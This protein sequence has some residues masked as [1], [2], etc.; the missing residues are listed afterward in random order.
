VPDVTINQGWSDVATQVTVPL[1]DWVSVISC[2]CVFAASVP[3]TLLV[4]A[5]DSVAG[6]TDTVGSELEAL[7]DTVTLWPAMVIVPVLAEPALAATE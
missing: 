1:P 4:A 3:A 6:E 5:N 7:C 2:A